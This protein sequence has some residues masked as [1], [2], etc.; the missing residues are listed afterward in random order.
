MSLTVGVDHSNLVFELFG[1]LERRQLG[2]LARR[3]DNATPTAALHEPSPTHLEPNVERE[4]IRNLSNL[5]PR[6][7]PL[8]PV[9]RHSRRLDPDYSPRKKGA[10]APSC[11]T[12]QPA[13]TPD[14]KRGEGGLW[15]TE[16]ACDDADDEE[17]GD[18]DGA[19]ADSAAAPAPASLEHRPP[20][21]ITS[22]HPKA[23]LLRD[24]AL[25]S[26]LQSSHTHAP[27]KMSVSSIP[28]RK[29]WLRSRS[30]SERCVDPSPPLRAG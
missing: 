27:T 8:N 17:D 18:D 16:E 25:S 11:P 20:V 24:L 22:P 23:I 12:V 9:K 5:S 26:H 10:S 13:T 3:H 4:P 15:L 29:P 28:A 2:L 6:R 19:A 21:L 7:R 30:P 1:Q 14:T